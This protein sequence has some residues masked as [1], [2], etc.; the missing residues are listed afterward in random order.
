MWWQV[1][2]RRKFVGRFWESVEHSFRNSQHPLDVIKQSTVILDTFH[3]LLSAGSLNSIFFSASPSRKKQILNASVGCPDRKLLDGLFHTSM[4]PSCLG[5][6]GHKIRTHSINPWFEA[7]GDQTLF[8][9]LQ[10]WLNIRI[11][12]GV[13]NATDAWRCWLN[14]SDIEHQYILT[15]PPPPTPEDSNV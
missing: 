2:H 7:L 3:M 15:P 14:C 5:H 10:P 9:G 4:H 13:W 11:I 8:N 12:C 1:L 6:H